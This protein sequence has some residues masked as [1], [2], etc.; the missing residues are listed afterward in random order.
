[1]LEQKQ[2]SEQFQ[3]ILEK[4]PDNVGK[5]IVQLQNIAFE[6]YKEKGE[7]VP[8][9][10]FFTIKEDKF[11]IFRAD[12]PNVI[13]EEALRDQVAID[14]LLKGFKTFLGSLGYD[15]M[16]FI[17]IQQIWMKKVLKSEYE[18]IDLEKSISE[19]PDKQDCL[20][21]LIDSSDYSFTSIYEK[22]S[23]GKDYVVSPEP[24][25]E[26]YIDKKDPNSPISLEH[27]IFNFF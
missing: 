3:K 18:K 24:I 14:K 11:V 5:G 27:G 12:D 1:M 10:G 9:K 17:M 15:I 16:G 22:I 23:S 25:E 7:V 2:K 4:F 19:S 8:L 20:M 26:I 21:F 13:P 6:H